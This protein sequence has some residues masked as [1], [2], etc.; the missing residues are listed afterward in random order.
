MKQKSN[1]RCKYDTHETDCDNAVKILR[2]NV[3]VTRS[4]AMN[5]NVILRDSR[6]KTYATV[7]CNTN[8]TTAESRLSGLVGKYIYQE[9][10]NS[11][12]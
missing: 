8:P 2:M 4:N 11:D 10:G 9:N 6:N 1:L 5:Y 12:R 3:V 7:A